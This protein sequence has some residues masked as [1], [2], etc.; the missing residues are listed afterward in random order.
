MTINEKY[1]NFLSSLI[2]LTNAGKAEW[3]QLWELA[4]QGHDTN[5]LL[6]MYLVGYNR[7]LYSSGHH[8]IIDEYQSRY[9]EIANGKIYLFQFSKRGNTYYVIALQIGRGSIIEINND[10]L[11]Q[12]E[13]K[14]LYEL[15][16][17]MQEDYSTNEYID[18]I[19][20]LATEVEQS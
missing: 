12:D 4:S 11:L 5:P 3:H 1:E 20:K 13:L 10:L 2:N 7:Y 16:I 14:D 17:N 15:I 6:D 9:A 18:R 8:P 19:I